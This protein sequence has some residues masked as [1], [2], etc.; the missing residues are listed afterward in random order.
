MKVRPTWSMFGWVYLAQFLLGLLM[1][2]QQ[3][4]SSYMLLAVMRAAI[5]ALEASALVMLG[6]WM[7]KLDHRKRLQTR[8]DTSTENIE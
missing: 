8:V 4:F 7:Y 1:G 6:V 3:L 5:F 2:W